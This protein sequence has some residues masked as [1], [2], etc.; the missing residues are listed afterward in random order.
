M[1]Q[2][3]TGLAIRLL[4]DGLGTICGD[5]HQLGRP[6]PIRIAVV[7]IL[8]LVKRRGLYIGVGPWYVVL[9]A[10]KVC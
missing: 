7:A 9:E 6:T 3:L 8:I 10:V 1:S 4:G 5:S 2:S